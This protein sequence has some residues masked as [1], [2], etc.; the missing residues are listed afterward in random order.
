MDPPGGVHAAHVFWLLLPSP[1]RRDA[2]LA[3]MRAEGVQATFH[4]VPLH[5]SPAGQAYG[6]TSGSMLNTDDFA[7][8]QLR[9][10]LWAGMS[11]ADIARVIATLKKS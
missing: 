6:R 1:E 10:P 3:N 11:E 4:Y 8:R 2:V 7:S 9:L 5:S